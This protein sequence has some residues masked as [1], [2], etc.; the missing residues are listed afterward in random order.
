V[1]A[2][3]G[4]LITPTGVLVMD[5]ETMRGSREAWLEAR[6][7]RSGVPGGY[8][9]GSSEVS[10]ILD[11]DG[12]DTPAHVFRSKVMKV[13]R[14]ATE[15]MVWGTLLEETIALEWQRRNKVVTDEIGLLARVDKPWHVSTVDRRVQECP[16][17]AGGAGICI[18][19][20]KNVGYA[21]AER[22]KRDLPD[23]I[24]AQI[25]HQLYV[26]GVDHA[27][28]A[29]LVGGN[30]MRQGV[31]YAEREAELMAYIVAEVDKFRERHLLTGI[32][33]EWDTSRKAD[34]LIELD[35]FTHP[36]RAGELTV[37]EIGDVMAYAEAAAE[38]SAAGKRKKALAARLR[39]LANG[40]E[41]V[42]FGDHPAYGYRPASKA[43]VDL[44]ALRERYPSA[45]ADPEVVSETTYHTLYIDQS[46]RVKNGDKS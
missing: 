37:E 25:V 35:K 22:W 10:S 1:T 26:T 33:P 30:T 6:R 43:K 18:A 7:S 15:P 11:L 39:Q 2:K 8:A 42:L 44:D 24:L 14:E 45:Y 12:V 28:Y 46:Y 40:A 19:E 27:H 41:L 17:A 36:I 3:P 29:C 31:V 4:D 13:K 21:T 23:R 9:I 32:E 5:I 38:E 20:I 34:K 16:L